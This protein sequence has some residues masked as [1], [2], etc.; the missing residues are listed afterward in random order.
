ML[1]SFL[2]AEV[3]QIVCCRWIRAPADVCYVMTQLNMTNQLRLDHSRVK[4]DIELIISLVFSAWVHIKSVAE[5]IVCEYD[6]NNRQ[7][8]DSFN[9]L[10]QIN[11][12]EQRFR[13][14]WLS[15][16]YYYFRRVKFHYIK[17]T[18]TRYYVSSLSALE[19]IVECSISAQK[20]TKEI[21][22]KI[23]WQLKTQ[24]RTWKCTRC[25]MQMSY[26][27]TFANSPMQQ[28][29]IGIPIYRWYYLK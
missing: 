19:E 21:F 7:N 1:L 11:Q 28:Q 4:T 13:F 20:T 10:N 22:V 17:A 23:C 6:R 5:N 18:D 2:C 24:I 9:N 29:F 25:T 26:S 15:R 3:Q 8:Y 12:L 14:C 27:K 16:S